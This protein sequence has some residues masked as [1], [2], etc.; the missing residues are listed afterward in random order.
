MESYTERRVSW[1]YP[2]G[3]VDLYRCPMVVRRAQ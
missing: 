3:G 2:F 1:D